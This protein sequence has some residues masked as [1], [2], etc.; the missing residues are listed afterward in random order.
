MKHN[1]PCSHYH[2]Y[3][4]NAAIG[5]CGT[6]FPFNLM[7]TFVGGEAGSFA[8]RENG[9][10]YVSGTEAKSG[11]GTFH[12]GDVVG[13]GLLVLPAGRRLFFT[14]NGDLWGKYLK[15]LTQYQN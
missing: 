4:N 10:Y 5:L 6:D 8:I 12:H 2:F 15:F 1:L 3:S 7:N 9:D 13:C 11:F 14:K